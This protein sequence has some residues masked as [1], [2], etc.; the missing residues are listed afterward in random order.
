MPQ[1]ILI[2][3]DRDLR[4]FV[5]QFFLAS[6]ELAGLQVGHPA[7]GRVVAMTGVASFL[8]G[9]AFQHILDERLPTPGY[10][11]K[12]YDPYQGVLTIEAES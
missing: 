10:K 7:I 11:K 3:L 9:V 5:D 4:D 6:I 12:K 8:K 2:K 1:Q